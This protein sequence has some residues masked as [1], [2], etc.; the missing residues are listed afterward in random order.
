MDRI[1]IIL[2]GLIALAMVLTSFP[3]G[4][5]AVLLTS[6]LSLIVI[7]LI[8]FY[9]PENKEYLIK[10]F[11]IA[12]LAR[13]S[14]G[15][16][17]IFFS[18]Q[19]FFGGD[20]LTYD[21]L[22]QRLVEAWQGKADLT[23]LWTQRALSTSAPGWGMSYLVGAIYFVTGHNIIIAQSFCA[24]IGAATVPMI[25]F[26]SQ[27]IFK[28]QRVAKISA[29]SI[30]LFPSFIIWSSQLMKDGLIIFL[31]VCAM[32]M[33]LQLQKKLTFLAAAVLIFSMFGII[34]LRFYIF[35]MVA[36]AVAGSFVIG[37]NTS[38]KSIVRNSIAIVAIGLALTYLGVLRNATSDIETYGSLERVNVSRQGLATAKSGYGEDID[39]STTGGAIA[40]IPVGLVYL[41]LAPFPWQIS[42][43]RQAITLPEM[44]VW[45]A[46]IPLMLSGIWYAVKNR[47]REGIPV[48]LFSLMLSLSYSIFQGNV[49]TAYRQRTQIQVFLFIFIAVGW[50]LIQEKKENRLA[51]QIENQKKRRQPASI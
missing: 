34:S 42:N 28:N 31:L 4:A 11:L 30:A 41:M 12:L 21:S 50:A 45:W 49:G 35:Y 48:L 8:R 46:C 6:I 36:V 32:T 33:V 2:S 20:A 17:I 9:E 10:I 51:L 43:L 47:L 16:L 44:L 1:L 24:V 7:A 26:C 40:A 23:N 3:N 39:V 5:I 22:G 29:L 27:Q 37:V 18:L 15:L 13:I 25:Y 14:F 38:V 19:D